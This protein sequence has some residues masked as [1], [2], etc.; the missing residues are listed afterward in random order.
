VVKL[1]YPYDVPEKVNAFTLD[2]KPEYKGVLTGIKGQYL[3]FKGDDFINIRSHE[4]Y[5][6]ELTIS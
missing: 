3:K 6:V 2:K 4:G 1:D 5:V